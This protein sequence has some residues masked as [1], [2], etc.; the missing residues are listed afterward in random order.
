[1]RLHHFVLTRAHLDAIPE[2]ERTLLVLLAHA[3]N[4]LSVLTKLFH[5]ASVGT[6]E[7]PVLV[8]AKHA[9]ALVLGRVLTG[10]LYECWNLL[11]T[12]FYGN[13][14]SR[15]YVPLL[16]EEGRNAIAE[17][18]RYFG[19]A[20]LIENVRN[21][22]AFHYSMERIRAGYQT[23]VDGD[24]LDVYLAQTN[25]NTLY[26]FAE[27][28]VGRSLM[29]SINPGNHAGA[30]DAL[31]A[32]TSKVVGWFNELAGAVMAACLKRH[33]GGDLYS[34]GGTTIDIEGAP[35]WHSIELPYF[36]EIEADGD[37]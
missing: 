30:I 36:I 37:P 35:D 10:K 29:T 6:A 27:T 5:F 15:V 7:V 26:S 19:R 24:P 22:F 11:R 3:A 9:Q 12:A 33:V 17:L 16:D 8:E 2:E 25:S 23:V 31:I 1:V 34:L 21:N 32:E 4:E 18:G 14:L 13:Q 20:N 28:I